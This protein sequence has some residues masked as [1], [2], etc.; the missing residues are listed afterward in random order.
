MESVMAPRCASPAP[1]PPARI[2]PRRRKKM[3]RV[4]EARWSGAALTL[5]LGACSLAPPLKTPDVATGDAY[6]ELG[7]W[8]PAQPADR[9]PRDS[10]WMLY[11]NAELD[12]L[13]KRLI[14]GNP[15]L[16]A[17]LA[18]YAQAKALTDQARAGL[19]PTLGVDASAGRN[20]ESTNAPLRGPTAPTYYNANTLGGSV[21]YELDLWGQIRNEVAAGEANA[22]ASAADLEN[23]RLS[24][25][26]QL[27]GDYIQLRSLDRDTAI[28]DETVD[29][30]TRALGLTEQ[31]HRAGSRR[32]AGADSARCRAFPVGA[33]ARAA[34]ADGT[35]D[36]GVARRVGLDVLDQATDRRDHASPDSKR[37]ALHAAPAASRHRRRAAAHDCCQCQHRG[38][39]GC[40]F[41]YA[42]P[43][44][45]GRFPE[46][47]LLEL[48]ERAEL[49]LG[50]WPQ[51]P[52]KRVR[53]RPAP[54]ASRPSARRVR[55][56][57]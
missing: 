56:L 49:I 26:G 24:L 15:T 53:W 57:R 33:D 3:N 38:C 22:A 2:P 45:S 23:A 36:C 7:P 50:H 14:A 27:A 28:L 4:K 8:T 30:Y 18:N 34:R 41:S 21:S 25:I 35:C 29:A 16:A 37:R 31:R 10:W 54:G 48:A 39:P 13:E 52:A 19:Y 42:H 6:K 40:V 1:R 17:A 12:E 9:L 43:W 47:E 51:R 5:L 44:G 20:R 46:H 55:P 11:D 32:L